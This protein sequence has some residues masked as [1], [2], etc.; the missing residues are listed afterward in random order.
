MELTVVKR[1][2]LTQNHLNTNRWKKNIPAVVYSAGQPNEN[3]FIS[4]AELKKILKKTGEGNLSTTILTLKHDKTSFKVV[5]KEVQYKVTNY[6][7]I[8]VDFMRVFDDKELT[9]NVPIKCTG[10]NECQGVKL[11]GIF[12]HIKNKVKVRCLPKNMPKEFV[13]D[14][15]EM[16]INDSKNLAELSVPKGAKL[17]VKSLKEVIVSV[18]KVGKA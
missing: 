11:G 16:N 14:V 6:E 3:I 9:V 1:E 17:A 13:I 18:G 8:H 15:R 4:E 10:I 5:V 2:K 12:R 7:I